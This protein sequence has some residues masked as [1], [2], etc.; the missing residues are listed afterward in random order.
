ML[1]TVVPRA[2]VP[3]NC[4]VAS[5]RAFA[6]SLLRNLLVR[7]QVNTVRSA[8]GGNRRFHSNLRVISRFFAVVPDLKKAAEHATCATKGQQA[9]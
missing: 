8:H 4:I 2:N 3:A 9:L 7:V 6:G 5:T 1:L